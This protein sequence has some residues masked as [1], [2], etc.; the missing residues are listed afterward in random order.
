[1]AF[2]ILISWDM[3]WI[4]ACFSACALVLLFLPLHTPARTHTGIIGLFTINK[5][6]INYN[7]VQLIKPRVKA[8]NQIE[9]DDMNLGMSIDT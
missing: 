2:Q 9:L 6:K 7:I 4:G 1:M 8:T 5:R 3:M